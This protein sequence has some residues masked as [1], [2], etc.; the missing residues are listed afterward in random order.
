MKPDKEH[1]YTVA[2]TPLEKGTT[3]PMSEMYD[4]QQRRA[5]NGEA[6]AVG[7]LS[8]FGAFVGLFLLFV[9]FGNGLSLVGTLAVSAIVGFAVWACAYER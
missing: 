2:G 8:F 3:T 5:H 9:A 1:L 4:P 7:I 6:R